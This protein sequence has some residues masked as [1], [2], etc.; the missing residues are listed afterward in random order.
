MHLDAIL[1]AR[2]VIKQVETCMR[3][4]NDNDHR[5]VL[6]L[7]AMMKYGTHT[8]DLSRFQPHGRSLHTLTLEL[9]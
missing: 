5:I 2:A 1:V 9:P 4:V 6:M 8:C 3:S 7:I